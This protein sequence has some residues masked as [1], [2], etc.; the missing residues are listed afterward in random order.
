M[1]D[2][3]RKTMTVP[4]AAKILGISKNRAYLAARNNQLPGAFR[5]GGRVL[6]AKKLF[7]EKT[8]IRLS[9]P[10]PEG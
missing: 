3:E 7:E 8:G 4:E 6:V 2:H 9:T 1:H 10:L 5:V